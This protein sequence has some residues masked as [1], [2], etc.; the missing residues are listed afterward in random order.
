MSTAKKS[1]PALWDRVASS[2]WSAYVAVALVA[3][4]LV[5]VVWTDQKWRTSDNVPN[6]VNTGYLP[7]KAWNS[8]S[9]TE[10]RA[11]NAAKA[12]CNA[13]GKQFVKQPEKI[14]KKTARHR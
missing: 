1:N 4:A 6:E 12:K 3:V 10:N 9:L 5:A 11:T 14:A 2:E 7:Y 8:M 13:E